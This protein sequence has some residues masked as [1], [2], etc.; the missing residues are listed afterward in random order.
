MAR[1]TRSPILENRTNR[2]KIPAGDRHWRSIGKGLALGYRRGVHGGT[3]YIRVALPRNR[4]EIASIG[5]ADD[6]R[7]SDGDHVLDFFQAQDKVRELAKA[8]IR[9]RSHYTVA[10]A[11]RDYL[12]WFKTHSKSYGTTETTIK[13]HILPQLETKKVAELT[14]SELSG[15]HRGLVTSPLRRRGKQG[16]P[17]LVAIADDPEAQRRRKSSANR[18]LTVLKAAL[19]KA[20][21]NEMVA[22]NAAWKR[23]K[24]FESVDG[25]RKVFLQPEQCRRLIS[26]A[27]GAFRD[28][29]SA[30]LYTG[31]RPGKEVEVIR[32]RDFDADTGTIH[33]PDGKT[34]SRDVQLTDEG[35]RFFAQLTADRDPDEIL[36]LK[37]DG[38]PWGKN[39]HAR[40]MADAVNAARLPNDTV[41]YSLRH[42]YISLALKGGANI[43]VLADSCGTSVEMITRHYAKFLA[44]DRRRMLSA[45]LPSFG[46]TTNNVVPIAASRA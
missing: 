16:L 38:T 26:V 21:E 29:C 11:C 10:D 36:L 24:P 44:S 30:L 2:A 35:A 19:N 42:T 5:Q 39:H 31:A 46:F 4:Y 27:P 15:W 37:D 23:V 8:Q 9:G 28:Y 6:H 43:K 25:T 18:I 22:S 41:A 13:A 20:W 12:A 14:T 33:V 3:W 7:E 45:A 34:G 40:P 1:S 32:V 17:K